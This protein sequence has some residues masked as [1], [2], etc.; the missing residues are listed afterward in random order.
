MNDINK[1]KHNNDFLNKYLKDYSN[2]E[3]ETLDELIARCSNKNKF[4]ETISNFTTCLSKNLFKENEDTIKR[5]VGE[6]S[7][8]FPFIIDK[9]RNDQFVITI[10]DCT[11]PKVGSYCVSFLVDTT[12]DKVIKYDS[13]VL[14]TTNDNVVNYKN[15]VE[16]YKKMGDTRGFSNI[17]GVEY[18]SCIEYDV[19]LKE[20]ELEYT[21]KRFLDK[22]PLLVESIQELPKPKQRELP[23]IDYPSKDDDFDFEY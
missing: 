3:K 1:L 18:F 7:N 22:E 6:R 9:K 14:E 11:T 20:L 19:L 10:M 5:I 8:N 16:E 2:K 15:E 17:N 13:F 21:F 23:E 4:K 12:L